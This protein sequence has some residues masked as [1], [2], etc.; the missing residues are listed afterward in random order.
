MM[1][2]VIGKATKPRCW[3]ARGTTPRFTPSNYVHYFVKSAAWFTREIFNSWLLTVQ[4]Q[5]MAED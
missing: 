4:M 5:M 3:N 2:L 1:S